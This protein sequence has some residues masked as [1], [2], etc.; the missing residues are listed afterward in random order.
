MISRTRFSTF[1]GLCLAVFFTAGTLYA[2][3]FSSDTYTVSN[4]VLF[5]GGYSTSTNFGLNAVI[6]QM[7]IGT[8]TTNSLYELF[9]GFLYFPFVSTPAVTATAGD[10]QVALTWTAA[11]ASTGWVVGGY[12]VGQSTTAGGPYTYSSVGSVLASTRTGLSNGTTY[13]FVIVVED[14]LDNLIATSTEVSAAPAASASP[15][16]SGG[17]SSGGGGGGSPAVAGGAVN[18]SGRAYPNRPITILKDAQVAVTTITDASSNFQ[19]LLANLTAGNY[20]FS[21][22]SED[23]QGRRS[24]LLTFPVSVTTGVTTNITG[25]FIAPTIGVDKSQ[26]R[27]GDDVAIFGQVAHQSEVT[28]QINSDQ[29]FFAKT[30]SDVNGVYLYNFDTT[31]LEYGDHSTK[32]KAAHGNEIS[33]Y[34]LAVPFVVG[35]TNIFAKAAEVKVVKGD[36]NG[37]KRVN[38]VDFSI[39][40]Y[41]YKRS[42]P[43][44][45]VDI[46][47]DGKVDLIDFS[48][49]AYNWTG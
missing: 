36:T 31:T 6:S 44:A 47:G 48:I 43:P 18:F 32:S 25:I 20:F 39:V 8:S 13:Y 9:G 35:N 3:E 12:T 49:M 23:N 22:Y 7:A 21:V 29:Q 37:D 42:A 17:R 16:P 2:Q 33:P 38:L 4:P 28:I 10:A 30:P 24:S 34:S 26:V 14:A 19:V 11:D 27:K 45:N 41:W 46:N 5:S 40:A 1:L 15:A